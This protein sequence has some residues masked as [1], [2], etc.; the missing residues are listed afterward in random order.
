MAGTADAAA[1]DVA[2]VAPQPMDVVRVEPPPSIVA[3]LGL[4]NVP[5]TEFLDKLEDALQKLAAFTFRRIRETIP[6]DPSTA[7]I[8]QVC[9]TDQNEQNG[10]AVWLHIFDPATAA[11]ARSPT[12]RLRPQTCKQWERYQKHK[13]EELISVTKDETEDIIRRA[14]TLAKTERT[15]GGIC[16]LLA[17]KCC[18]LEC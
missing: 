8:E 18:G 1:V 17:L 7:D 3:A 16:R 12:V 9:E 10:R 11:V 2:P 5:G 4:D 6:A 15:E 13:V 14:T